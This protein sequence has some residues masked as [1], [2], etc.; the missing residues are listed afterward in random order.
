MQKKVMVT[1]LVAVTA[2]I[3]AMPLAAQ[4]N[5][6]S[7]TDDLDTL[8]SNT[9]T[10]TSSIYGNDV[11]N[12]LNYHKYSNVLSDGAKWFGFVTGRS[13]STNSIGGVADLGYGTNL[14]GIYLGAWYRGNIASQSQQ[15]VTYRLTP[16]W[17]DP[18][19]ILDKT[20]EDTVYNTPRNLTSA[21]K[22]EI[23]IGVAGQGIKVG[24]SE[25]Y[26]ADQNPA[27]G[28]VSVIDY[29]DGRKDYINAIKDKGYKDEEGLLKPYI[30]WGT[31]LAI[32][33]MNLMPYVDL[34]FTIYN[35]SELYNRENYT[36]AGGTKLVTDT[37]NTGK[38]S[39]YLQPNIQVG[40]KIDLPKKGTTAT[41]LELKY[42]ADFN[43]YSNDYSASGLSGSVPGTVS[44]DGSVDAVTNYIDRTETNTGISFD[45]VEQTSF[46][47]TITPAYKITGEPFENFKLG[48]SASV[49]VTFG[50]TTS[51]AY[52]QWIGKGTVKYNGGLGGYSWE[53][54]KIDYNGRK[55][56]ETSNFRL[57]LKLNFGTQY[58]LIPDRLTINAGIGATPLSY[59][60]TTVK[61][62]PNAVK[63]V[64]TNK[65]YD[66]DGNLTNN[67]KTVNLKTDNDEAVVTDR[68]Y[69]WDATLYGG[70]LFNFSPKA[71]LDL[72]ASVNTPSS[73]TFN[74]D[75]TN[76]N[77]IFTFKF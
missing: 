32:G 24:F 53:Y 75:L 57:D 14:G 68:W 38:N 64:E 3:L 77:V 2:I 28:T 76:V 58:K 49:P 22:L 15:D 65:S 35:D 37:K 61:T 69:Q 25:R 12:Y 40:A 16:T 19:G 8:S 43:I 45:I 55:N 26:S 41:Q 70:F 46:M 5:S 4:V 51:K 62:I 60:T 29:Q 10:G 27:K 9:K 18:L 67:T 66:N 31:N 30:G 56:Q 63:D 21:N 7:F 6:V 34:G 1:A 44:W 73:N 42:N 17:N 71:A 20:Q 13:I 52:N 23:L 59:R 72:G 47:N 48:F 33:E 11:D 39:G 54:E 74:L 36:E 50:T